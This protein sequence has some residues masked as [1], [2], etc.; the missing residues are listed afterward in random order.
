MY[1]TYKKDVKFCD[2]TG[3][4]L[5]GSWEINLP[6]NDGSDVDLYNFNLSFD[7]VAISITV[8]N[9]RTREKHQTKFTCP[10]F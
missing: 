10:I 1:H 2:E 6:E 5:V 8:Q 3:V 9:Q 7:G 4:T